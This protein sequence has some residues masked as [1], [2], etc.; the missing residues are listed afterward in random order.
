VV[1][2]RED[3]YHL[4]QTV[5]RLVDLYDR[6]V[7]TPRA[8]GRI[9]RDN[10]V[11]GVPADD[12]L[13]VRAAR[14]LQQQ[15]GTDRGAS[16]VVD[17]RIPMGAGLGGG[18][19]DAATTLLALNC[20]W[21]LG[22]PRARLM[23]TGLELGADV[24]FFVAGGDAFVV[25]IGERV[26]PLSLRPASYA[27]VHPGVTVPTRTIFSAPELTRDSEVIKISDFSEVGYPGVFTDVAERQSRF[28]NDLEPV[29]ASRFGEVREALAWLST[30]RDGGWRGARGLARMS[31]S[32]SS[33]FRAFDSADE[34]AQCVAAVPDRWSGWSVN[35]LASHPHAIDGID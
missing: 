5:M 15:S 9:V 27:L 19:S 34:A 18:S 12:D 30:D 31:G 21:G 13:A 3:G 23:A 32:G 24:P 25:G 2:R 16:L 8:D 7:I 22:W 35:S 10:D 33:V 14:L 1:G 6:I 20:L 26:T 29:A 17:K 11:P 4:I 28:R